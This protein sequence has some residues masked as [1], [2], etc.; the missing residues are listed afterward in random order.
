MPP[1]DRSPKPKGRPTPG[2]WDAVAAWYDG[3]VGKGGSEHHRRVAIPA[4]LKLLDAQPGERILDIGAG[5]GVLAPFIAE[6]GAKYT[7]IDVSPK[8][9]ELARQHHNQQGRFLRADAAKLDQESVVEAG[10]FD[11]AIFLLSIQDMN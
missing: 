5:Q 9:L 7:G 6:A 3:W 8:L 11:A 4:L 10:S 2:G 1:R